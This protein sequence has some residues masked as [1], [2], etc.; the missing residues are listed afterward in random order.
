MA[1]SGKVLSVGQCS[2]DHG[3]ISRFLKQSFGATV[4][5]ADTLTDAVEQIGRETYDLILVNRI[6]DA[7]GSE[8]LQLLELLPEGVTPPPVML[9]S[10]YADAQARAVSAGAV[11]GFGKSSLQTPATVEL[12]RRYLG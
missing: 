2:F 9:V 6:L 3:S 11:P 12:L 5:A 7:D 4:I 1:K 8:G 10:N